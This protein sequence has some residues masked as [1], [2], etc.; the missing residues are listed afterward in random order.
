MCE[1]VCDTARADEPRAARERRRR[2]GGVDTLDE[3]W[4]QGRPPRL[5]LLVEP[6][7]PPLTKPRA[8]PALHL[9]QVPRS[10]ASSRVVLDFCRV[11]PT[12]RCDHTPRPRTRAPLTASEP[13]AEAS[14]H[15]PP[16][17]IQDF[18]GAIA[19]TGRDP[20]PESRAIPDYVA[21]TK[22]SRLRS[23]WIPCTPVLQ[24]AAPRV[25]H[26][27]LNASSKSP[28]AAS[29][30]PL[31]RRSLGPLPAHARCHE[32]TSSGDTA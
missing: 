16:R 14:A 17:A 30:A 18:F 20:N 27:V 6:S 29:D 19:L 12:H 28:A 25:A 24:R 8:A 5:I 15:Q 22:R 4:R 3:D 10:G 2:S 31:R 1:A 11:D 23:H 21:L 26:P 7:E 13:L 9:R 32:E